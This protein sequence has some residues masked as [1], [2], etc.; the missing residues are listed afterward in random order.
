MFLTPENHVI[1]PCV[2]ASDPLETPPVKVFWH[3]HVENIKAEFEATKA[4]GS[5]AAEEWVKGLEAEG[6]HSLA[7]ASRWERWFLSGGVDEM[8][9]TALNEPVQTLSKGQDL[10]TAC[11]TAPKYMAEAT[12][13]LTDPK[14]TIK[15]INYHGEG[16]FMHEGPPI[17][18]LTVFIRST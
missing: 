13:R 3:E 1:P 15:V 16:L 5:A 12:S 8:R 14:P 9:R 6:K 17:S 4:F 10:V 11:L 7:D 18:E 2:L